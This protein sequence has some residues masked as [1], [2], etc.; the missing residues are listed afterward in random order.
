MGKIIFT[1]KRCNGLSEVA[2]KIEVAKRNKSRP[3]YQLEHEKYE[4]LRGEEAF[5]LT[6]GRLVRGV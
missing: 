1:G 6:V 2:A 4:S 5:L 3:E